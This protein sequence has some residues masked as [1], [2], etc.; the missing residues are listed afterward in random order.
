MEHAKKMVLIPQENVDLLRRISNEKT[1]QTPGTTLSRL[2]GEMS[3]ILN[4]SNY[5]NEREKC[6]AY[7]QTLQRYLYF[8][9]GSKR[10]TK[11]SKSTTTTV[12]K[13]GEHINL[14]EEEEE[15]DRINDSFILESVPSKYRQKAKLLL[16][17]L[18]FNSDNRFVWDKYGVVSIDGIR[19]PE[20]NIIDL[21]NEAMRS[22]KTTRPSN[23]RHFATFLQS[24][25]VPREFI[26]N[27]D[28]WIPDTVEPAE[29]TLQVPEHMRKTSGSSV[30]FS[31]EASDDISDAS[32][33]NSHKRTTWETLSGR[34]K[35]LK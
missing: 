22:R 3:E 13:V 19:I 26:G 28:F 27:Q 20:Y 21:V 34:K 14:E 10:N 1:I 15:K 23:K 5:T 9:E 4:S 12:H 33:V 31:D 8:V 2:D 24:V 16:H 17:H 18:H 7:L 25:K 29:H 30:F 35:N 32:S 6:R 11:P